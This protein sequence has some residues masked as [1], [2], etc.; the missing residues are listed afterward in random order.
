MTARTRTS[1]T[2]THRV[3]HTGQKFA[4]CRETCPCWGSGA[5]SPSADVSA[6]RD[7]GFRGATARKWAPVFVHLRRGPANTC[8]TR[9]GAAREVSSD[10]YQLGRES[11]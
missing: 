6:A 9:E 10:P 2:R 11:G 1:Q 4:D 8:E 5:S 7:E 3:G